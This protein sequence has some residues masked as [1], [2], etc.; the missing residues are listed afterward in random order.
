[1]SLNH[2]LQPKNRVPLK[3]ALRRMRSMWLRGPVN[4]FDLKLARI[5]DSDLEYAM[6]VREL[7]E[8]IGIL[9]YDEHGLLTWRTGGF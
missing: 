5:L 8:D 7:W 6:D 2:Y 9:A 1:M 3:A 4:R